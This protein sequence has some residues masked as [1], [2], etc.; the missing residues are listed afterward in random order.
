MCDEDTKPSE[1]QEELDHSELLDNF[2]EI[3]KDNLEEV[4]TNTESKFIYYYEPSKTDPKSLAKINAHANKMAAGL[5]CVSY[6]VDMETVGAEF[7]AFLRKRSSNKE[8]DVQIDSNTFLL[9]NKDDDVWFWDDMLITYFHGELLEQVFNFYQGVRELHDEHEL[10]IT[11]TENDNHF[12]TFCRDLDKDTNKKL[13]NLRRFQTKNVDSFLKLKFWI[14]K[15]EALAKKLG[16][17]TDGE[18]GDLYFLKESTKLNGLECTANLSGRDVY[19]KKL[20]NICDLAKGTEYHVE[21][22]SVA[23]A[24][25]IIVNDFMSFAQLYSKYQSPSLIVY[26]DREHKDYSQILAEVHKARL[27][28]PLKLRDRKADEPANPNH[29]IKNNLLFIVS[30][31]PMLIPLMRLTSKQPRAILALPDNDQND[32]VDLRDSYWRDLRKIDGLPALDFYARVAE[33]PHL[34]AASDDERESVKAKFSEDRFKFQKTFSVSGRITAES[35]ALMVEQAQKGKLRP[36]FESEDK[37]L[38]HFSEITVG[39]DFKKK[40]LQSKHD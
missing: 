39:E 7:K 40:V 31:T 21:I 10:M 9:A 25:P 8:V 38:E 5:K 4:M 30:T 17:D 19:C 18:L 3:T 26:C 14:L 36:F 11:L 12:I 24:F 15:N 29:D 2:T 27:M 28:F 22:V 16:I 33:K 34:K 35:I 20:N 37:P 32:S 6:V 23:L 1:V 13:K